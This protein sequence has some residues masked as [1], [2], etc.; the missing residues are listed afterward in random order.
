MLASVSDIRLVFWIAVIPALLSVLC[1][2]WFVPEPHKTHEKN[3]S[4]SLNINSISSF[5]FQFW[6]ILCLGAALSAARISDAFLI[7]RVAGYGLPTPLAPLILV[8]M[9]IIYALFAWPIGRWAD[10]WPRHRLLAAGLVVLIVG[11]FVLA[12]GS[13]LLFGG[14]GMF[15]GG[16]ISR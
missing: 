11:D 13:T 10:R 16:F 9:N 8:A 14:I 5:S 7:L 2:G 4:K 6:I 15:S 3:N 12:T 1:L